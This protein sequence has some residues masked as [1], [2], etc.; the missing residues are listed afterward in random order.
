MENTLF[1]DRDSLEQENHRFRD[2][3]DQWSNRYEEI[4]IEKEQIAK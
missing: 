2:A 3:I 4:R 1:V